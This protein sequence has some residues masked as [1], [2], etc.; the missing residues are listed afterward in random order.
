VAFRPDKKTFLTVLT[1]LGLTTN[2]KLCL[3]AG[4]GASYTS[5]QKWLDTAG[6]GYDFFLGV[7][8]SSAADDPTFN[9]TPGNLTNNEYWSSDGGDFFRYDSANETW[10]DNLH[11][12]NATLTLVFWAYLPSIGTTTYLTGTSGA[13]V[14][15]T[16][17]FCNVRTTGVLR[18]TQ[19]NGV[20]NFP[21]DSTALAVAGWNF[22]AVSIDEAVPS[23]IIQVNGTQDTLATAYLVPSAAAASFNMEVASPGNATF[24]FP[25]NCRIGAVMMWDR[26]LSASELMLLYQYPGVA[27]TYRW[28][29]TNNP[30]R[31][32][33]LNTHINTLKLSLLGKDK[34]FSAPGQ[35]PDYDWP[36]PKIP[37]RA[38]SLRTHLL[39]M[40]LNLRGKDKF[41]FGAGC[42]PSY[43]W[44]NPKGAPWAPN[45]KT[46]LDPVKLN[47]LGKDAFPTGVGKGPNY[48]WP[49]PKIPPY[50]I[51]LR[52]SLSLS[53]LSL[54]FPPKPFLKTDWPNPQGI[55][56][57]SSLRTFLS[58]V[59]PLYSI[60]PS[61]FYQ[62]DWPLVKRFG[63]AALGFNS[64]GLNLTL[65]SIPFYQT[66]W[67]LPKQPQYPIATRNQSSPNVG[68]LSL[69]FSQ[70]HWPL[71]KRAFQPDR[72]FTTTSIYLNP[73][74]VFMPFNMTYWPLPKRP[75]QFLRSFSSINATFNA[76]LVPRPFWMSDWPLPKI[77]AR[78]LYLSHMNDLLR[79]TLYPYP[80]DPPIITGTI[81]QLYTKTSANKKKF[82]RE[83]AA[84]RIRRGENPR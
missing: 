6:A 11:K 21:F 27:P 15:G 76:T 42:G 82:W 36:N 40:N 73:L 79:N 84:M 47:L 32:N 30:I 22:L 66:H 23:E 51:S 8:G 57:P 18:F 35:G 2:L 52:T 64:E 59:N 24:P 72:S 83:V 12:D 13:N 80:P 62:T 60:I 44:P 49:N 45:L 77:P 65:L 48:Y 54:G 3:D 46:H 38:N 78:S 75:L 20:S 74:P 33:S 31:A 81:Q 7:D 61:P 17:V 28:P 10:M 53:N 69:P 29:L 16:G 63:T 9:G 56:Y 39:S 58:P 67:P 19:A 70:L 71:P 41:F 37:L 4:D 68:I 34:F 43:N 55:P 50:P 1:E 26:A 25:A 5:G 14:G